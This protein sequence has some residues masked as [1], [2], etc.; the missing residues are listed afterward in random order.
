MNTF[1]LNVN[2]NYSEFLIFKKFTFFTLR[3]YIV[4]SNYKIVDVW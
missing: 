2:V 4:P 3:R 1:V